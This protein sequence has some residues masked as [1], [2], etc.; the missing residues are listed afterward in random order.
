MTNSNQPIV[1]LGPTAS[2]K[3][4]LAVE[5]AS[6]LNGAIISADSRQ[7]Y[8]GL[9]IGTGKDLSE[10]SDVPYYLIDILEAG[11]RYHIS[12]FLADA[13]LALEDIHNK[14]LTPIICGGTGHYLQGLLQGYDFSDV[15]KDESQRQLL[16]KLDTETLSQMLEQIP[17]PKQFQPDFSTR[18]R[19]I[20]ALEICRWLQENS[21]YVAREPLCPDALV[22]GINPDLEQRRVNISRRLH[23]RIQEGLIDEVQTLLDGGITPDQLI[24]YGLEYKYT[25][26]FL[27]GQLSREAYIRKLETE[28]HRYAKRQMTYFRKMEK[29]GIKIHWLPETI[30]NIEI[31]F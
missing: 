11:E 23:V 21:D 15:P 17:K 9:D 10:Y 24:Y 16:E 12:R 22:Y 14:K 1:I 25:T 19:I 30:S 18:K 31:K 8:K 26:L 4:K 28:I 3:T 6:R 13:K 5:L 29:D 2:G 7:V 20:R 27:T